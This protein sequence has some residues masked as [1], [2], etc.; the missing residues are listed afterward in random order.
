MVSVTGPQ[1]QNCTVY[2]TASEEPQLDS[3]QPD[4]PFLLKRIKG[5]AFQEG[6]DLKGRGMHPILCSSR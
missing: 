4:A 6:A 3:P 1:Q 5:A 2:R